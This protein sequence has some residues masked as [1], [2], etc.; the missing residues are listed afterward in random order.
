[1]EVDGLSQGG[2]VAIELFTTIIPLMI[3]GFNYVTGFVVNSSRSPPG[4]AERRCGSCCISQPPS[5]TRGR[6]DAAGGGPH[7]VPDPVGRLDGFRGRS[8][9]P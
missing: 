3:I 6:A 2:L 8:A 1:M 5:S 4:P 9:W 7:R